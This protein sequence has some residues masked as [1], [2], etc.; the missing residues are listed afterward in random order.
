MTRPGKS[1]TP[2]RRSLLTGG[3]AA[4]GSASLAR[5]A[6]EPAQNP[7]AAPESDATAQRQPFHGIHQ[8]GIV[9]PRPATGLVAA[10]DVTATSLDE[11]ERLFRLLSERIAF[12]MQ[13]GPAPTADPG[14]PPP[15]SGILGPVIAPDNLTITVALGA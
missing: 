12:L 8:S 5:A 4:I 14:F 10:F 11:L 7:A 9:T 13:G 1:F 15:D 3:A 2:S 6:S